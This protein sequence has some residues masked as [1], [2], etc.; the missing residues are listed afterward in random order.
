MHNSE[1]GY[2]GEQCV[3][4]EL[5]KLGWIVYQDLSGK[6]P[7]DCVIVKSN[8]KLTVQ[9]KSCQSRAKYNTGWAVGVGSVRS[10]KTEN[11]I[12]KF[13]NTKQDI[14]A[15]Y[16]NVIDKVIFFVSSDVNV[17]RMLAVT[18]EYIKSYLHPEMLL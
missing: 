13:D 8:L 11:V 2:I 5:A 18:D 3:F 9:V 12:H 10:N 15:I 4:A 17:G 6:G 7:Y 14:L 1:I 16:L